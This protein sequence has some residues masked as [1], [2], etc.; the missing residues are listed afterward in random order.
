MHPTLIPSLGSLLAVTLLLPP[1]QAQSGGAAMVAAA[2]QFLQSLD[3]AQKKQAMAPLAD[4]AQRMK[5]GFVPGKYPGIG[6]FDLDAGQRDKA[7]ALLRATLSAEGSKKVEGIIALES[8]LRKLESKPGKEATH[9]D[10]ARYWFQF[11][12]KPSKAGAWSWRIQGHHVSL[13]FAVHHGEL[14]A[15]SPQFLGTNPH[16]HRQGEHK[17]QRVLAREEDLARA[18]LA[19]LDDQQRDAAVQETKVPRD[20]ILG[21]SRPADGIGEKVGLSYAA[22]TPLQ[23]GVLWRLIEEYVRVRYDEAAEQELARIDKAGRDDIHFAWIGMPGR[24]NPHYYRIHGPTFVIEYDNVQNDANHVHTV[25][26][27]LERDFGGDALRAHHEH[28]HDHK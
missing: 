15:S 23:R 19:L 20:V 2:E 1:A 10:P 5:W 9:R 28:D 3:D 18:L 22:M 6:L 8:V 7:M 24:G 26:R 14:I 27:D 13:H 25:L 17:G 4:D 11:F 12:G 16:E 21:P